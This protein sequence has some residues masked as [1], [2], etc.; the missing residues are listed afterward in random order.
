MLSTIVNACK[1]FFHQI[2]N[3]VKKFTKPET[4]V[5]TAGAV[6]D[7]IRSRK[8]LVAENAI[9]RQQLIVLNRQV[10]R[11]KFTNGDRLRLVLLSRLTQFWDSALHL[12]QP[13]TLLR[14]HRDLFRRYWKRKSRPKNRKPRIPQETIDLIKGMAQKNWLW[15]AEKIQGELLKLG[16]KVSK[17]TIQKYMKKVR[18]RSSQNWATFLK[19]HAYEIWA[20]DFTTV[21]SL[22]F[23]PIYIFVIMELE[24]RRIV[25]TAVT[26]NPTDEWTAQQLREAT[27]WDNRPKYLIRDNDN[28]FSKK[29][30]AVAKSSGIK[31]LKTPF[32]TPKTNAHC[33]RLIGTM[34]RECLDHFLIFNQ[35]QLKRIVVAIVEY[36][37]QHRAHQGI[38]QRI[39]AKLNQP[40]LQ[41]SNQVKNKVIATPMLNGLHH[42]YA[43]AA[44]C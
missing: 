9:L 24:S 21:T 35:Y 41:L 29:F 40:R 1:S 33:E 16:I 2:K 11:P 26:L 39:P 3:A 44:A 36:Y 27:P 22:F 32:Q 4:T 10:K 28:K 13:D 25:H 38:K 30:S 17:R 20:C 23:K 12:V 18:K 7:I 42:S 15:G 43:Y 31:E 8:D 5:L 19:N 14:W 37:N 34:K 6:S